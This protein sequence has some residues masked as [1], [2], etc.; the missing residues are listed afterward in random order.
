MRNLFPLFILM[1]ISP[2]AH[3]QE[4]A[5]LI[6]INGRIWTANPA[7]PE[8]EAIACIGEK[9]V[10]IGRTEDI[11]PLQG[12][13]TL[14][15]NLRGRRVVPGFNDA[16]VHF[17]SGGENLGSVQLRDASSE[18]EFRARIKT[19]AAKTPKGRWITGGDW[20]HERWNPA[21]LPTRALIDDVTPDNPVYVNRLDGHMCLAN[22]VALQRAG[23]T[24]T[25][26]DPPGG[27]IVRDERGDPTGIL[28][29][30]AMDAV[31]RVIPDPTHD[32]IIEALKA[33]MK[34]AAEHG[35]T[36]VQDM[37][38]S[39]PVLQ[40]YQELLA[41]S[42]LTVRVYAFQ[43][44]ATWKRLSSV[45]IRAGFGNTILKIGGLK[46][47]ADGS[48][49]STTAYFFQP[50]ADAP[51]TS[52]LP[53]E[54]MI[55][56]SRMAENIREADSAGLQVA[57]HAIGDR[58]NWTILGMYENVIR[59]HGQR[60]RRFRIEHAQHLRTSEVGEFR[61]LHVIA[62]MQPYHAIDDG[63]WADKRL[64]PDRVR[65]SYVFRSLLD[66]GATLAFGSDW[67]VAPMDPIMGIYAAVTRS[68]LDGKRPDGWIPEQKIT[69]AEALTAF[70]MGS[71]FASFDEKVK[72]SLEP[73]K[74][75]DL[76]VLSD[77]ILTIPPQRIR[78]VEVMMTIFNGRIVF[79]RDSLGRHS[80]R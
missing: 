23:I 9:I 61:H 4:H 50:Y 6:L 71:A 48:L 38:A 37:S 65:G 22:S 12:P 29:D 76:A 56:E 40:A 63:R 21:R 17:L 42:E 51:T 26:P 46:G 43:P 18:E 13:G 67:P 60:D 31:D 14:V 28:K 72:G 70:T 11:S 5:D 3:P 30:A 7:R 47:F 10:A 49:G 53:N 45:G 55:P 59:N 54:E 8:V 24:R 16:H 62:S 74:L 1:T 41:D 44:L 2:L 52:G 69:A 20:D 39:P 19:F 66:S 58:A 68:T 79:D 25:T 34:Y 73:G 15:V 64:G 32:E 77:D 75:A 27:T 33:A 80:P 35:V 78:D 57:I 36:S